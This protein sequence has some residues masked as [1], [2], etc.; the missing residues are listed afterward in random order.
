M[1]HELTPKNGKYLSVEDVVSRLQKVFPVVE[2]SRD[3]ALAQIDQMLDYGAQLAARGVR[4]SDGV[5]RRL[6][7]VRDGS[8]M[9]GLAN[10]PRLFGKSYLSFLL[11]PGDPILI[12]YESGNHE[13][14]AKTLLE[15]AA[16]ALDY[17][18]ALV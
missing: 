12:A 18:I 6:R 3:E 7:E 16:E 5:S 13:D 17:E 11:K 8:L 4:E 1:A 10:K 9:I 2:I 14:A 15:R